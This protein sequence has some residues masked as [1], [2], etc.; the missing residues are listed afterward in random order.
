[1]IPIMSDQ[2]T[3]M[4]APLAVTKMVAHD[5]TVSATNATPEQIRSYRESLEKQQ[6]E[7]SSDGPRDSATL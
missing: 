7:S 6:E 3:E 1:M 2:E 4:K 5:A